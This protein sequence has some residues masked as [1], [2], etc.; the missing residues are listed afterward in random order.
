M[1]IFALNKQ[2]NKYNMALSYGYEREPWMNRESHNRHTSFKKM[3]RNRNK[4]IRRLP[5]DFVINL[6]KRTSWEW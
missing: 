2:Y 4:K 5:L 3:K 6:K 1:C